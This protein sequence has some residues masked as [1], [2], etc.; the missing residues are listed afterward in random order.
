MAQHLFRGVMLVD[1]VLGVI[2]NQTRLIVHLGHDLVTGIN[3]E[4]ATD[5]FV[6]QALADIDTRWADLYAD[7]TVDTIT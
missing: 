5:A 4:T 7:L 2:S 3:T 1:R 6:L